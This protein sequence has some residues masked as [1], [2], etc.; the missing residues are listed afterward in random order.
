MELSY[1]RAPAAP[2]RRTQEAINSSNDFGLD[3]ADCLFIC[4]YS[5]ADCRVTSSMSIANFE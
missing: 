5:T 4:C 3:Q 2:F 1:L